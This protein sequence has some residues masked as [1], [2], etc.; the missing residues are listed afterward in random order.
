M[1]NS[2]SAQH[3]RRILVKF[4]RKDLP[5]LG[6]TSLSNTLFQKHPSIF[7][8]YHWDEELVLDEL[9]MRRVLIQS[10]TST[11]KKEN[12]VDITIS[13]SD[14]S[15]WWVTCRLWSSAQWRA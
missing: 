4:T 1:R 11:Y 10:A 12:K 3:N 8:Q 15:R 13:L 9:V 6:F 2:A 5:S 14:N 7:D